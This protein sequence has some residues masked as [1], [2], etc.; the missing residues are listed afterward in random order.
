MS[1]GI[2]TASLRT[3]KNI[4][5]IPND[6]VGYVASKIQE[7]DADYSHIKK[8]KSRFQ[9]GGFILNVLAQ[10]K[11][12]L[13]SFETSMHSA[14]HGTLFAPPPAQEGTESSSDL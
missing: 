14:K 4:K 1:L 11:S 9:V 3:L 5:T 7:D 13:L 8:R 10:K 12:R 2:L 6:V